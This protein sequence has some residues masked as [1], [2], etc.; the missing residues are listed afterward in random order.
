M[1]TAEQ[2]A[3]LEAPLDRAHAALTAAKGLNNEQ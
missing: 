3:K 1:F 2:I